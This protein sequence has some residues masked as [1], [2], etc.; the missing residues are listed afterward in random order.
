M[1]V[2]ISAQT[3]ER[4]PRRRYSPPPFA[5]GQVNVTVGFISL[6]RAV[7]Q[8]PPVFLLHFT[9]YGH[10][11]DGSLYRGRWV[12]LSCCFLRNLTAEEGL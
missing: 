9:P 11:G 12:A 6:S 1:R 4:S 3:S 7:E 8:E 2:S 5:P 10:D